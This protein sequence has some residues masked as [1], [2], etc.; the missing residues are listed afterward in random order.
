MNE[1]EIVRIDLVTK[2]LEQQEPQYLFFYDAHLY[3]ILGI[4]D[5]GTQEYDDYLI[6]KKKAFYVV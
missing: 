5:M 4:K 3:Y 2:I 6:G 1:R